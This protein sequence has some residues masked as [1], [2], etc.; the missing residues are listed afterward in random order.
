MFLLGLY[1]AQAHADRL[2]YAQYDRLQQEQQASMAASFSESSD[3]GPGAT[4]TPPASDDA[5]MLQLWS[6]ADWRRWECEE[7][8][9]WD[10]VVKR[11]EALALWRKQLLRPLE[12][13]R[14][15]KAQQEAAERLQQDQQQQQQRGGGIGGGAAE[16][17][18]GGGSGGG[19]Q[20]GRQGRHSG[21]RQRTAG[22]QYGGSRPARDFLGYYKIM[23]V[24]LQGERGGRGRWRGCGPA[25]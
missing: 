21:W 20:Y 16:G 23:G 8:W 14:H 13:Q 17:G 2:F 4:P 5:F 7:P 3:G 1:Y 12:R 15:L 18:E 19:A 25:R 10:P 11:A 24:D 9:N 6:D 22:A